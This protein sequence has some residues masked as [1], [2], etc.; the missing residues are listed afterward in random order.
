MKTKFRSKMSI[1]DDELIK[2][3]ISD[4]HGH[5]QIVLVDCRDAHKN[6]ED[7]AALLL[8]RGSMFANQLTFPFPNPP[9]ICRY[10]SER[11]LRMVPRSLW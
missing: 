6:S 5:W 8:D 9:I 7:G 3:M 2:V 11:A 1:F 10:T 4:G